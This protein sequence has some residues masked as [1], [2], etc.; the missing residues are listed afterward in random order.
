MSTELVKGLTSN[1]ASPKIACLMTSFSYLFIQHRT[2]TK[3]IPDGRVCKS[4]T[5]ALAV[6]RPAARLVLLPDPGR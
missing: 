5:L 4:N 1:D 6:R 3:Y 2:R